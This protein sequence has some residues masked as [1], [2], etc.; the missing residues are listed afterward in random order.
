MSVSKEKWDELK[1]HMKNLYISEADLDEQFILASGKGGQ[2]INKTSSCVYIKH[3]PSG[4]EVKCQKNRSREINRFFA[5]RAL[6]EKIEQNHQGLKS[7]KEKK[8]EKLRK[9]KKRRHRRRQSKL[10]T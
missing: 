1:E 10:D 9:Q 2:K 6:C 4:I 7:T 8:T 3:L 5:R